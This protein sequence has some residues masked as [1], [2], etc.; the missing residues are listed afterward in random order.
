MPLLEIF[1]HTLSYYYQ[2]IIVPAS[3]LIPI[4]AAIFRYSC[5]HGAMKILLLYLL[6][7]GSINL[8]AILQSSHNNLPLLH[9]Y[10]IVEFLTLMAYFISSSTS[11]K[12]KTGSY[13]VMALFPIL[14]IINVIF[15]Q[16]KYQFNSYV[17][18]LE[19]LIFISYCLAYFL[20]SVDREET[21]SWTANPFN[22]FNSGILLYFSSS[23]FIFI[24][25]NKIIFRFSHEAN[26]LIWN[27]HNSFVIMLYLLLALGISKCKK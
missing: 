23:L 16:S 12:P 3:I 19:A 4:G 17:R 8:L 11:K 18:P 2:G 14:C 26:M 13:L 15:F 10:T 22:L 20:R 27:I 25:S 1:G 7:T 24:L 5:L 9:I 6:L 21:Q